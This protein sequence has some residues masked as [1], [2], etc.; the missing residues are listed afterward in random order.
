[1]SIRVEY[2]F[3][4][5]VIRNPTVCGFFK[6]Y[7]HLD[8]EDTLSAAMD[9]F[10]ALFQMQACNSNEDY[11][12]RV[13]EH[14]RASSSQLD[15]LK[16]DIQELRA[17]V[18]ST[19]TILSTDLPQTMQSL[20]SD[21][22]RDMTCVAQNSSLTQSEKVNT[23]LE[24]AN[25]YLV[26]KTTLL[27]GD[28]LPKS[29]D[30]L[31]MALSQH[32]RF[33]QDHVVQ[34]VHKLGLHGNNQASF[35]Q[36]LTSVDTKYANLFPT[37][38]QPLASMVSASEERI[39]KILDILKESTTQSKPILDNIG[40][41]FEK[42]GA[43]STKGK[44]GEQALQHVLSMMYP[45]AEIVCTAGTKA[46]GDFVLRRTEKPTILFENK[47]Y[48]F[49]IDKEEI[50]KFIR[51]VDTQDM[52]GVFLSQSS[53]IAFKQN[54]QIDQ[55]KGNLL[56]YVQH[57]E[58]D[59]DKIRVAVDLIDTLADRLAVT[60]LDDHVLTQELLDTINEEF[61]KF[62]AQKDAL[63]LLSK[64]FHRR[65]TAQI[66]ELQFTALDMYLQTKYAS[67]KSS[68]EVSLT[69]GFCKVFTTTNKGSLSN[70]TR[71]CRK[72]H[73]SAPKQELSNTL[74]S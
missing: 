15:S 47:D 34:E 31:Q 50:A 43:S 58:Y 56:V 65:I 49:N 42:Y 69:C 61:Q 39:T 22:I 26:D 33:L 24:K 17:L 53:G 23:L 1:M 72:K 52:H 71:A 4:P 60:K 68:H 9:L 8:V 18:H 48:K 19:H 41:F 70:H 74:L 7:P 28:M 44:Q 16:A 35:Q 2:D 20:R 11:S 63:L 66:G 37:L 25:A 73:V 30:N 38:H 45:S 6:L 64:D 59:E 36:F 5:I 46:A 62:M 67:V 57:C 21:L 32:L 3:E 27:L 10:R 54:Y 14:I 13:V 29:N 55:H 12:S 40:D 51:D